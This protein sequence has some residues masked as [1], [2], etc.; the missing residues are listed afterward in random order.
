MSQSVKKGDTV[1]IHYTGRIKD[2]PVFDSS[3]ERDPLEFEIGSGSI[4]KGLEKAV[5]G[6]KPGEK[7]EISVPPEEGYGDLDQKLLFDMP[8]EKIPADIKPEVGMRLQLVN[9][10]GQTIPVLITEIKD[11]SIKI[12]A[13][14]PLAGKELIFNI[15]LLQIV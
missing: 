8:K 4:I 11:E 1:K 6:M 10:K 9:S 7:K 5:V 3:V 15:E 2:G 12:D 13:N 14:H